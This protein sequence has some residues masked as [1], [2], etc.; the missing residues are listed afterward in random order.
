MGVP[1]PAGD[2]QVSPTGPGYIKLSRDAAHENTQTSNPAPC[3]AL[4]FDC[5]MT[6]IQMSTHKKN[7]RWLC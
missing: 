5:L 7:I 6:L 4:T 2:S 3:E 1:G